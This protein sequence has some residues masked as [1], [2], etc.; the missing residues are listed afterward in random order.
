MRKLTK[1]EEQELKKG[2]RKEYGIRIIILVL[3]IAFLVFIAII[4]PRWRGAAWISPTFSAIHLLSSVIS[5]AYIVTILLKRRADS[6]LLDLGRTKWHKIMLVL[7]GLNA[8]EAISSLVSSGI[9][10]EGGSSSLFRLS[11]SALF[12]FLGLGHLEIKETGISYFGRVLKWKR[13]ESRRR[14][15]R[16]PPACRAGPAPLGTAPGTGVSELLANSSGRPLRANESHRKL[17]GEVCLRLP[18]SLARARS[19]SRGSPPRS[20]MRPD[21]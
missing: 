2:M 21:A 20:S 16:T 1:D 9:G 17:R 6:V 15:S 8:F 14:P 13:I 4:A 11:L 18:E 19:R 7:A 5:W 12:F 10:M 3:F